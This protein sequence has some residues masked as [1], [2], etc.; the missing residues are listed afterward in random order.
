M[1]ALATT[2]SVLLGIAFFL[3]G[4]PK[5]L[6]TTHYRKRSRHWRLPKGLLPVIGL[7]EVGGATLLLVGAATQ[8]DRPAIAGAAL[9]LATMA[10]A[11]LTH[12]RIADPP[13]KALPSTLLGVLATLDVALLTM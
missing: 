9:L 2:V 11:T 8:H 5:I 3:A 12:L 10:G 7:V 13:A 6:R 1:S 4:V